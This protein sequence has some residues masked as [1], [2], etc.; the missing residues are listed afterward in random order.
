VFQ[1]QDY[2][3][4]MLFFRGIQAAG[5]RLTIENVDRGLRA[6]PHAPSPNPWT[7][8]AYFNPDNWTFFKDMMLVRWDPVGV[9]ANAPPGCWRVVEY[10]KRYRTEDW[11]TNPGDEGFDRFDEWPCH[12]EG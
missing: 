9:N 8:A 10:G 2:D 6:L 4:V 7:P 5:P 3:D 11:A 1:S 12:G